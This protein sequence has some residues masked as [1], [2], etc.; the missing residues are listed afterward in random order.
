MAGNSFVITV[1]GGSDLAAS[2]D[3]AFARAALF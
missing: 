1:A 2:V 3:P